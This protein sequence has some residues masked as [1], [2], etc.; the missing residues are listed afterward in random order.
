MPPRVPVEVNSNDLTGP[1]GAIPRANVVHRFGSEVFVRIVAEQGS[2]QL[3]L[4]KPVKDAASLLAPLRV[5]GADA[6]ENE[7]PELVANG[8]GSVRGVRVRQHDDSGA[9]IGVDDVVADETGSLAA[10][11]QDSSL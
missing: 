5:E 6:F 9:L 2:V 7:I 3:A 10:V 1:S 8:G 4:P 11:A